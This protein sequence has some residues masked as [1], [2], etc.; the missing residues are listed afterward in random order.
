VGRGKS[1]PADELAT[2]THARLRVQQGDF[3]NAEDLLREILERHPNHACARELLSSIAGRYSPNRLESL[4]ESLAPPES[5]DSLCLA[6]ISHEAVG[7]G[8]ASP[9]GPRIDRLKRWLRRI[10]RGR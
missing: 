5:G 8:A 2:V 3:R 7:P 4:D 10:G 6:G 1:R 9:A